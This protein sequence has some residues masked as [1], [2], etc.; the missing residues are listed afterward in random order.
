MDDQYNTKVY[1]S[2]LPLDITEQEFVDVMQK[3]GLVMK[4]A[5]TGRMKIKLYTEP[6]TNQIKGDGLCSYIKVSNF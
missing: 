5:E 2:N 3:C 6:G 1:V 4:D